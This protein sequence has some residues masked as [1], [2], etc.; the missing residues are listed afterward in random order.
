MKIENALSWL[1]DVTSFSMVNRYGRFTGYEKSRLSDLQLERKIELC[2]DVYK[3]TQIVERGIST[4]IGTVQ[5]FQTNQ[6]LFNL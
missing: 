3:V 5:S 2:R 1:F 6:F 4:K